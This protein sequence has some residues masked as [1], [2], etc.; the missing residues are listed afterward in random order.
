[1]GGAGAGAQRVAVVSHGFFPS[2]GGS[3]RYHLF[4]ARAL[5]SEADVQVFTSALNV[6][7]ARPRA[8]ESSTARVGALTVHYLPSRWFGTER[9]VRARSLWAALRRFRPDLVWSNHP[10]PTADLGALYAIAARRPWLATYHAD[11]S[12]D[13]WSHR[14]YLRGEMLLLRRASAVL[15]TSETYRRILIGRGV[16]AE[17]IRVVPTGPYIGDGSPPPPVHAGAGADP[18][19]S[20]LFVGA[21]DP[22]HAYKRLD[23]LIDAV[24]ELAKSHPTVT[25]EV[26]GDGSRR[27]DYEAQART[28]GVGGR[29]RFLGVLS[30]PDLAERYARARATVLPAVTVAEGFGTVA[31]EAL[32]YGCPVVV[33]DQGPL[34]GT[35]TSEGAGLAFAADQPGALAATL[36]SLLD[37]A[38]LRGRL[39]AGACRL[40]PRYAWSS[41]LPQ[42]VAPARELLGVR[43]AGPVAA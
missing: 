37:D 34:A 20:F 5:G 42:M 31:V 41:L 23:L 28:R 21:L 38:A 22:A 13:R 36:Q 9:L 6:D 39:A 16:R 24:A 19:A 18:T 17:R 32:H 33:S 4:T 2:V 8:P 3:E 14:F 27:T 11:V 43:G 35:L 10:S 25:L 12:T 30:D 15:V 1:V 29:V 26:V 7:P 40:A